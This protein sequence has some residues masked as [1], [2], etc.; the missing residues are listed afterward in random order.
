MIFEEKYNNIK[1]LVLEDF[2]L[3]EQKIFGAETSID[4]RELKQGVYLLRLELNNGL[5]V[6]KFTK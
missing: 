1:D 3:L 4:V 2:I 5:K 6:L